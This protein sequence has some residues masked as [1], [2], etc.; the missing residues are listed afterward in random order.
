MKTKTTTKRAMTYKARDFLKLY[1]IM[2]LRSLDRSWSILSLWGHKVQKKA[3]M[4]YLRNM[5]TVILQL[6]QMRRLE[7]AFL[8]PQISKVSTLIK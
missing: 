2:Y 1:R 6:K 5:L 4:F 7:E 3:E 8:M